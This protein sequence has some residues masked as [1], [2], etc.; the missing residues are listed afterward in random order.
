MLV[1]RRGWTLSAMARGSPT[2]AAALL[3]GA[4]V[5]LT[6]G[7]L[8][9]LDEVAGRVLDQ[10]LG[11][12]WTADDVVAKRHSGCFETGDIAGEVGG[13]EVDSF[14]PPGPGRAPSGMTRPAELAGPLNSSRRFPRLT[15]ANAGSALD[16][17]LKPRWVV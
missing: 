15:S 2:F 14:Q 17:S 4:V 7:G 10:D 13:D 16:N 12:A 11:A 9:E 3:V 6:A 1:M 8:E 5:V